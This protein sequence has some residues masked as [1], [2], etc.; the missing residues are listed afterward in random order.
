MMYWLIMRRPLV[1]VCSCRWCVSSTCG[2]PLCEREG[3]L[4]PDGGG[5]VSLS[6]GL[7]VVTFVEGPAAEE[8]PWPVPVAAPLL[9]A[10]LAA[11]LER[12]LRPCSCAR[13]VLFAEAVPMPSAA[14]CV[15]A[16]AP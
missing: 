7:T 5:E 12:L 8:P 10:A 14:A 6:C 2:R 3:V 13:A 15:A 9:G 11:V 4:L 16:M 1:C